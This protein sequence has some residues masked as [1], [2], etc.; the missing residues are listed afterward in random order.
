MLHGFGQVLFSNAYLW[1]LKFS[2]CQDDFVK[3]TVSDSFW[4]AH[5]RERV[6]LSFTA[7]LTKSGWLNDFAINFLPCHRACLVACVFRPQPVVKETNANLSIGQMSPEDRSFP[8]L[9][10]VTT[11]DPNSAGEITCNL[12]MSRDRLGPLWVFSPSI[13]T[14][15]TAAPVGKSPWISFSVKVKSPSFVLFLAVIS[16][17]RCT[18]DWQQWQSLEWWGNWGIFNT[19]AHS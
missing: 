17:D 6:R 8:Q 15:K 2:F 14:E 16:G 7:P 3:M 18:I 11:R 1:S 10:E 9:W 19:L 12:L 4:N 5:W 13:L